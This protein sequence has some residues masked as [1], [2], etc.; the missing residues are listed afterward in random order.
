MISQKSQGVLFDVRVYPK[1]GINQIS[2]TGDNISV[3]LKS[4]PAEGMANRELIRYL[5]GLLSLPQKNISILRGMSSRNKV[6]EAQ[7]ITKEELV[8]LL[9]QTG[10]KK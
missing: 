8:D 9:T 7:G 3:K 2:L 10:G 4:A 5:S 6:I 1:S